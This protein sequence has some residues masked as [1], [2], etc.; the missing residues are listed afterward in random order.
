MIN[1]HQTQKKRVI[2]LQ[3]STETD[4]TISWPQIPTKFMEIVTDNVYLINNTATGAN[5]LKY[6]INYNEWYGKRRAQWKKKEYCAS[7]IPHIDQRI[8][9]SIFYNLSH[10]WNLFLCLQAFDPNLVFLKQR[11]HNNYNYCYTSRVFS[12]L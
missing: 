2:L 8:E 12:I 1:F 11:K 7:K 10:T 3:Q 5:S 6:N 9:I 4:Q